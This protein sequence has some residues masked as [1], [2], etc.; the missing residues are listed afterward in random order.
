M[1]NV[2]NVIDDI[3]EKY[4]I[5]DH[6]NIINDNKCKNK[7]KQK[8]LSYIDT[9][10]NQKIKK[11]L[12]KINKKYIKE[13]LTKHNAKN[14]MS[15]VNKLID[16][17]N[18]WADYE[19]EDA[20][21]NGPKKDDNPITD[22]KP[23]TDKKD[24]KPITDKKDDKPITDKKD[25]KPITDKKDNKGNNS[26]RDISIDDHFKK[27]NYFII[28]L[29]FH[30]ID[31]ILEKECNK[32]NKCIIMCDLI[33]YKLL[34]QCKFN[35]KVNYITLRN[36]QLYACIDNENKNTH[37]H[38][39]LNG[40]IFGHIQFHKYFDYNTVKLNNG[41]DIS[42]EAIDLYELSHIYVYN[43]SNNSLSYPIYMFNK[44]SKQ[45]IWKF[46][47]NKNYIYYKNKLNLLISIN[48]KFNTNM[49][50]N[51]FYVKD[52]HII[53]KFDNIVK[54]HIKFENKFNFYKD[55]IT[56]NTYNFIN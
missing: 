3:I 49:K 48:N 7:I 37:P 39:S 1:S 23:I 13:L 34:E 10:E 52:D 8:I 33:Q 53:F 18:S 50:L 51:D 41:L 47:D 6:I 21:Y 22:D 40:N 20:S 17:G 56:K 4:F 35:Y 46:D 5:F 27:S 42:E 19:I 29:T 28:Y 38:K 11:M 54:S 24:D 31:E 2:S 9:K 45:N 25:D 15:I 44:E 55:D 43:E 12:E 30:K 32:Y 16:N 26:K 36:K 14:I